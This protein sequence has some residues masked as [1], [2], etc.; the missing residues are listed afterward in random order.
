MMLNAPATWLL[1]LNYNTLLSGVAFNIN[2]R[3][4]TTGISMARYCTRACQKKDW[5]YHKLDCGG[6]KSCECRG[7]VSDRG[8]VAAPEAAEETANAVMEAADFAAAE[9]AAEYE[10]HMVAVAASTIAA[11]AAAVVAAEA[12][13]AV[14]EANEAVA[15]AE[16]A[17]KED[18]A[19]AAVV[20]D[21]SIA[22]LDAGVNGQ[23]LVMK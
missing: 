16:A 19:A 21:E 11:A 20:E 6:L 14:V 5:K 18:A 12:A 2:S 22:S 8:E 10:A 3:R 15:A 23:R 17:A 4:Y 9:A 1:N 13:A 7:C